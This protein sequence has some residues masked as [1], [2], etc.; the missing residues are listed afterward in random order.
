[1]AP[2]DRRLWVFAKRCSSPLPNSDELCTQE[3]SPETMEFDFQEEAINNS[4]ASA[5]CSLT[6]LVLREASC[7]V[8]K[9]LKQHY[10]WVHVARTRG[11]LPTAHVPLP[12]TWV[13]YLEALP[14]A[15]L[16]PSNDHSSSR[17]LDCHQMT[18][19]WNHSASCFQIPDSQKP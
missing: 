16:E 10:G 12:A 9:I 13:S 4:I 6:S 17:H 18:L 8:M 14:P 15:P 3:D 1:M 2:D 19:R 5:L 7:H 11:P